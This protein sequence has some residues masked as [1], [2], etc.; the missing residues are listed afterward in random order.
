MT[1]TSSEQRAADATDPFVHPALFY[2]DTEEY[3]TA[4]VGFIRAGLADREPVAVAVPGPNLALIRNGLGSDADSVLLMDMAE[5]GRNPGRIIPCVLR[6]FADNYESGRVRI[7]GEPIWAGRSAEEYPACVQH[8]A[9]INAAFTNR[10]VTILCPYD[11][12]HL[13]PAV[14]ED[15]N[16]THPVVIDHNGQ[17]LSTAYDPDRIVAS[18]NLPLPKPPGTA[19]SFGFDATTLTY[20]RRRAV[21]YA[22]CAGMVADRLIDFELI[23]AEISTNSVVHGGGNGTLTLWIEDGRLHCR[24]RD[25][26]HITNTLAGRLPPSLFALHGRG[27][28]MVNHLADLVRIHTDAKATTI[29]V[30]LTLKPPTQ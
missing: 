2:H 27:L 20:T 16:A 8:E 7:V 28:I 29:E 26:G 18:Y 14:L 21:E 24:V 30:H 4:I 1:N 3:V 19:Q 6:A 22:R 10:P 12:R 23:V 17:R 25:A 15:A 13:D 9:L 11:T 5:E